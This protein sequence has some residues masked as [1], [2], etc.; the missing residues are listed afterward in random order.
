MDMGIL[1]SVGPGE[2]FV[3]HPMQRRMAKQG[4]RRVA[5]T[6]AHAYVRHDGSE[7]MGPYYKN[8]GPS[9]RALYSALVTTRTPGAGRPTVSKRPSLLPGSVTDA[10]RDSQKAS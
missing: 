7:P 10:A 6:L 9:R 1:L 3:N 2:H 8:Q 5:K 4:R